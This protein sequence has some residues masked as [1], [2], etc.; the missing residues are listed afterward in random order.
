MSRSSV[1]S[2]SWKPTRRCTHWRTSPARDAHQ[3]ERGRRMTARPSSSVLGI[4]ARHR[5]VYR[6]FWISVRP[7]RSMGGASPGH[8]VRSVPTASVGFEAAG[9]VGQ[10]SVD[11]RLLK[12][13]A[14]GA[15]RV[16]SGAAAAISR[17]FSTIS[18]WSTLRSARMA[19]S[20][21]RPAAGAASRRSRD[22]ARCVPRGERAPRPSRRRAPGARA[23]PKRRWPRKPSASS[24][25]VTVGPARTVQRPACQ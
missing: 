1:A 17:S 10:R 11:G 14:A 5:G 21:R 9:G 3:R 4:R 7:L 19:V 12:A 6:W 18:R 24:T 25:T 8:A 23:R 22:A 20:A 2:P 16:G 13:R 15:V